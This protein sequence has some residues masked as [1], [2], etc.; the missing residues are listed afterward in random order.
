VG[1]G[2]PSPD[3][4]RDLHGLIWEWVEDFNDTLVSSDSRS[5]DDPD[6]LRF[7][8]AG[9]IAAGDRTDYAAFMRVA[10]RSSLEGRFTLSN[11][12]FRCA[13][14]LPGDAP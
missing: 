13:R 2:A 12:G 3:G 7:C 9:A 14:D 6:R 11:L 1:R 8:G 5:G 4:V 10:F